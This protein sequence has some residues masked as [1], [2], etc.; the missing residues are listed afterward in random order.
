MEEKTKKKSPLK[1]IVDVLLWI[2][3][4][5][6][7]IVTILAFMVSASSTGSPTIGNHTMMAVESDS[8]DGPNGFKKGD[9][10]FSRVLESDEKDQ[11]KVGDVITFYVDLDQDG[12][13]EK[14][15]H[16]ITQRLEENGVVKYRTKGDK[17]GLY[18]D[19][20]EIE[21]ARVESVWT[22]KRAPV[23]GYVV[24]LV[25]HP[26]GFLCCIVIPMAVLFI[27]VLITFIL[28]LQK[29]KNKDKKSISKEDEEM[30]KQKAVEEY[31]ARQA[32]EKAEAEKQAETAK[33]ETASEKPEA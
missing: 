26:T 15:T 19:P 3:M 23:V 28:N 1:T 32:A 21:S 27:Y 24:S 10:I 30:I 16:R 17:A 5:F 14:N 25:Q 2:F 18:E 8:M 7:C 9:L 13:N 12:E 6:A 22:G 11:L 20:E 29:Y 4:I 33:E 31:L